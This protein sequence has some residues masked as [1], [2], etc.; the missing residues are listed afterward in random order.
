MLF[1]SH[2]QKGKQAAT[3]NTEIESGIRSTDD[4]SSRIS[5]KA[6]GEMFAV[7]CLNKGLNRRQIRIWSRE[8]Q[9]YSC[10]EHIGPIEQA[11]SYK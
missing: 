2:I 4:F 3:T 7:S 6:N 10:N 1:F 8:G 9:L 5:W 11:L